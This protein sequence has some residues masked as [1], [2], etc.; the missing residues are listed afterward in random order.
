VFGALETVF[1]ACT[2]VQQDAL[3]EPVFGGGGVT[4]GGYEAD[5]VCEEGDAEGCAWVEVLAYEE[6]AVV[7]GCGCEGYNGLSWVVRDLVR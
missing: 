7:Q 6:V 3:I 2:G 5:A 1:P 4:G